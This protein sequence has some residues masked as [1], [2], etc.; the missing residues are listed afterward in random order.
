M[1]YRYTPI[2]GIDVSPCQILMSRNL[3]TWLPITQSELKPF[4]QNKFRTK[5]INKQEKQ[6]FIMTGTVRLDQTLVLG[7]KVML[8]VGNHWEPAVIV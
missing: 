3:R 2:S 5:L 7:E 6:N 1:E 8:R 4:V